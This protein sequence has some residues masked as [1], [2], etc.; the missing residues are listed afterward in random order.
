[1]HS[2]VNRDRSKRKVVNVVQMQ[3]EGK[4]L[5][6]EFRVLIVFT[7]CTTETPTREMVSMG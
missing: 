2:S 3:K 6:E 5:T 7:A 4:G 1:M